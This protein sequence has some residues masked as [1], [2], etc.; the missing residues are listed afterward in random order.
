MSGRPVLGLIAGQGAFPL[1]V[2]QATKES[3]QPLACVAF[4]GV[5]NPAIDDVQDGVTW[6]H[7]GEVVKVFIIPKEAGFSRPQ[8][9]ALEKDLREIKGFKGW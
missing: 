7:L 2:A 8:L 5:S 6:I 4:H 3:G 1:L 9:E